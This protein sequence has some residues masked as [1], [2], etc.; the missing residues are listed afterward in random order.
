MRLYGH[1]AKTAGEIRCQGRGFEGKRDGNILRPIQ[2]TG[3]ETCASRATQ[4]QANHHRSRFIVAFP[5][6]VKWYNMSNAI[7][8]V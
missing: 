5:P 7:L 1:L 4:L 6:T 8:I 3:N 2:R